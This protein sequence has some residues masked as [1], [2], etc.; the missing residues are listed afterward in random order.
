LESL[1]S[2][3]GEFRR[4]YPH[5]FE[6]FSDL[7]CPQIEVLNIMGAA[8]ALD[9]PKGDHYKGADAVEDTANADAVEDAAEKLNKY[10]FALH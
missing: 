5:T 6:A 10:L 2:D 9:N 1:G 3:P 8:L 4:R 7:T